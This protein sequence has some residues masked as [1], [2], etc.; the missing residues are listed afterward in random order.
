MKF[1]GHLHFARLLNHVLSKDAT[2]G[3]G[4]CWVARGESRGEGV[5]MA[6]NVG[7]VGRYE[8]EVNGRFAVFANEAGV[9]L[10]A[11]GGCAAVRGG[12]RVWRRGLEGWMWSGS[13]SEAREWGSGISHQDGVSGKFGLYAVAGRGHGK[14]GKVRG[15]LFYPEQVLGKGIGE[16]EEN[17]G[18][19]VR[20]ERGGPV[21]KLRLDGWLPPCA[22]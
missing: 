9:G 18:V 4:D 14:E 11:Y 22:Y 12:H 6:R 10:A 3:V 15:E 5:S 1:F 2:R 7:R 21:A 17:G 16:D 13:L 20:A 8:F 19:C